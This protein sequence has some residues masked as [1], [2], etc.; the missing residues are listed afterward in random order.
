MSEKSA[1]K[2]K[3]SWKGR[4]LVYALIVLLGIFGLSLLYM[5]T[6]E[7]PEE[8]YRRNTNIRVEVLNGCGV[9]RLALRVTNILRE[10]GFNIVTIGDTEQQNF[11]E[12]VIIE[13]RDEKMSNALYFGERIGCNNIGKDIDP[14]L[15]LEVTLILGKDY[16]KFFKN[17]EEEF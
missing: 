16:Q 8:I 1:K 5:H 6:R 9:N 14:A 15:Y 2:E 3:K 17:V 12:T 13:R 10:Q 7:D 11:E 4:I